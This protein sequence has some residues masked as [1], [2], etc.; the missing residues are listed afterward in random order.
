MCFYS[1]WGPVSKYGSKSYQATMKKWYCGCLY[2]PL[3]RKY[4][5]CDTILTPFSLSLVT[6]TAVDSLPELF[7]AYCML[8]DSDDIMSDDDRVAPRGSGS[9]PVPLL[10]S[11][12]LGLSSTFFSRSRRWSTYR[13]HIV[14]RWFGLGLV[15]LPL[16]LS[17]DPF[18]VL[19]TKS[20]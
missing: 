20:L 4:T 16:D 14:L 9:D 2:S 7:L 18:T 12:A 3:N 15:P 6:D 19:W 17:D 10:T 11:C 1:K 8:A 5:L 13:W